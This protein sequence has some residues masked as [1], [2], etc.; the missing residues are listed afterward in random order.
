M[1]SGEADRSTNPEVRS[2][3]HG[4]WGSLAVFALASL[5]LLPIETR[6][7]GLSPTDPLVFGSALA[8]LALLGAGHW[9]MRRQ[10]RRRSA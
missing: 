4:V 2:W 1:T 10:N 3:I 9:A 6:L 8:L 7:E 5:A